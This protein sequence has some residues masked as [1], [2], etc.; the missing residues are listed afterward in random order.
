M[1]KAPLFLSA[2]LAIA[3]AE[4]PAQASTGSFAAPAE[5]SHVTSE[6]AQMAYGQIIRV[7]PRS[8]STRP[9]QCKVTAYGNIYFSEGIT[10]QG[11]RQRLSAYSDDWAFCRKERRAFL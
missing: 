10:E 9:W 11:A 2:A 3:A 8:S 6:A 4:L 7:G 5:A 1:R